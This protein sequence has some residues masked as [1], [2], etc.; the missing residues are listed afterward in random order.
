MLKKITIIL[1]LVIFGGVIIHAPVSV[2]LSVL[3][4]EW[5]LIIKSWKE[6]LVFLS[7]IILAILLFKEK[8]W[9]IYHSPL[10]YIIAA[11]TLLHLVLLPFFGTSLEQK[12][13]GLLIDLR[14]I[15]Y[16][17]VAFGVLK[18]YPELR[19]L[20]LTV[21]LGGA[22]LVMIFGFLQVAILPYDILKYLGYSTDTIA[23][24]LTV[25]QNYDYIRINS[26]LRGPNP[27][28]AYA[29]IVMAFSASYWIKNRNKIT[30]G[31]ANLPFKDLKPA[32]MHTFWWVLFALSIFVLY[33]S[34][35]RSALVAGA[36]AV[37]LTVLF[38][39]HKK[40]FKPLIISVFTV[41]LLSSGLVY[42]FKDTEFVSHVILHEDPNEGNDVNS[43]DGHVESL[44]DGTDRLIRQP[45]GAGIGSTGS[46]SLFGPEPLII[47]NQYLFV[48]HEVGWLGLG[49][50]LAI[51]IL[52][53]IELWG[54]RSDWLALAVFSS[55]VGLALVGILLPVWVDETVAI[56]WWGLASLSMVIPSKSKPE[57]DKIE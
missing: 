33:F 17:V 34:Y 57:S 44:I 28:G 3:F 48:A 16:F 41:G 11:Y 9:R 30:A 26:T 38:A 5:D 50:F 4:P 18:L 31:G 46:A 32:W 35:S 13:A 42:V 7:A 1:I 43:N 19:R 49:L 51:F 29:A 45:W 14:Y 23:A 8:K 39:V 40:I 56:I 52:V 47:E 36:V 10:F 54:R 12:A 24:Y 25:D 2:G 21:F 22:I 20:F 53:M 6:V 27:L 55:G 37:G 15:A